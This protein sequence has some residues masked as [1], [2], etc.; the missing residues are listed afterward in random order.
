MN[1]DEIVKR[2]KE[3]KKA[4][5][6]DNTDIGRRAGVPPITVSQLLKGNNIGLYQFLDIVESMGLEINII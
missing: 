4:M 6:W 3:L 2:L 5:N 1:H